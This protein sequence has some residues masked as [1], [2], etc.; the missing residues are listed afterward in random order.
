[1]CVRDIEAFAVTWVDHADLTVWTILA[2]TLALQP[3]TP[4]HSRILVGD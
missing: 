4:A 1:M 2:V 3:A